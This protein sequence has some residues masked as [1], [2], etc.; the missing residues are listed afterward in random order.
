[1]I[2]HNGDRIA[3]PSVLNR[4]SG[5]RCSTASGI[6]SRRYAYQRH[7]KAREGVSPVRTSSLILCW[8]HFLHHEHQDDIKNLAKLKNLRIL[9]IFVGKK[10]DEMFTGTS[11][12]HVRGSCSTQRKSEPWPEEIGGRLRVC[13]VGG[14]FGKGGNIHLVTDRYMGFLSW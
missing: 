7:R 14:C 6:R 8:D 12:A 5:E 9:T 10:G 2:P 3:R 1:M 4:R 11:P 13:M